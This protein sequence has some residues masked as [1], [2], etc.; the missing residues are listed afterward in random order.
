MVKGHLARASKISSLLGAS[1]DGGEQGKG[2]WVADF[3][4][5]LIRLCVLMHALSHHC[6][7]LIMHALPPHQCA[8]WILR[9]LLC[10]SA[11]MPLFLDA[12]CLALT[13]SVSMRMQKLYKEPPC[14]AM[15]V[16]LHRSST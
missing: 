3:S 7:S 11:H 16:C 5:P 9:L 13:G 14:V 1:G 6:D 12:G 2:G 10:M 15:S 4:S 8:S